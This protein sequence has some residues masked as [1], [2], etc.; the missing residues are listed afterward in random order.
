MYIFNNLNNFNV[1]SFLRPPRRNSGIGYFIATINPPVFI[2][3]L[4]RIK[5]KITCKKNAC[6]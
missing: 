4:K 6:P 2:L 5:G 3:N 1:V